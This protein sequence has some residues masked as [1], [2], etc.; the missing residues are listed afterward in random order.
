MFIHK[1]TNPQLLEADLLVA[2]Y[3]IQ[4]ETKCNIDTVDFFNFPKTKIRTD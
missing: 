4:F 1:M 2:K 3:L